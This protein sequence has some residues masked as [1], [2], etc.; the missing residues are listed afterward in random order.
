[1]SIR[2]SQRRGFYTI[3]ARKGLQEAR[4]RDR[5][6]GVRVRF[7][8]VFFEALELGIAECSTKEEEMMSDW[9][10]MRKVVGRAQL[11]SKAKGTDRSRYADK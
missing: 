7:E 8:Q 6:L 10:C 3:A 4:K 5:V 9:R 2:S 11:K 1:M